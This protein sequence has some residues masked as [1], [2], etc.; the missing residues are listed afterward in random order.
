MVSVFTGL[1]PRFR[2]VSTEMLVSCC[3]IVVSC[4]SRLVTVVSDAARYPAPVSRSAGFWHAARA[5]NIAQA[6]TE[7]FMDSST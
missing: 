2:T 4:I 1:V 7:C 6:A 3:T 5:A